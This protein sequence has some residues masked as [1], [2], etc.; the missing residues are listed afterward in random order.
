MYKIWLTV[1]G[2]GYLPLM[3]GTWASGV[4]LGVF[5]LAAGLGCPVWGVGVIL[6]V[7]AGHGGWVPMLFLAGAYGGRDKRNFLLRI[8]R[9]CVVSD[10]GYYQA[11]AGEAV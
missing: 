11:T 6:L 1:L 10:I 8:D 2:T 3:P 4:V 5:V 7:L 9:F